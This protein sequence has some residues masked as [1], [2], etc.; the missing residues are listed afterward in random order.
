MEKARRATVEII[1]EGKDITTPLDEYLTSFSYEDVASGES[2]RIS[3]SLQD[4]QKQW[5]DDWMPEKGSR[6]SGDLILHNWEQDGAEDRLF[7]GEFEL[8]DMS[9]SGRPLSCNLGAVSIPRN[10]PFS[11]QIRTKTWEG[12]TI[13]QIAS[14]IAQRASISLYY[15][16]EDILIESIE[17]NAQTDSKFL[18]S[19]CEDYGLAMKLYS[20]KIVIFD[21]ELYENKPSVRAID[22]SQMI[23]WNYKSTMAGTYT[24]ARISYTDPTNGEEYVVL[25]GEGSRILEINETVDNIADAERK[26]IAK[27]NKE[28]KKAMTM[29]VT[30]KADIR[31]LGG[32][33]VDITGLGDKINGKYSI[34][35]ASFNVSGSGASQVKLSLHRVIPRIKTVSVIAAGEAASGGTD[36]GNNSSNGGKAYRSYTVVKGDTLWG[37]SKRFYGNGKDYPLIYNANKEVIESTAK[38]RGKA[39]SSNGH[40]IFPGTVLN[41]PAK[42]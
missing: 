24:G 23:R 33:C 40:W 20:G 35:K 5:M 27:L 39:D 18:L 25:I 12:A 14:E 28:N 38:G 9:F 26:G 1:Y 11:N 32:C 36:G 34:D 17:Q 37:I 16:A 2:D 29:N 6:V 22:E 31:L 41:I 4:I 21:E 3:L 8:D 15:E 30:L 13:R 19:V 10:E 7:C 42:E